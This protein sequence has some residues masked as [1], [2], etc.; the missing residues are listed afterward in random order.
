MAV[1]PPVLK[2]EIDFTGNPTAG[3]AD[4]LQGQDDV[5]SF[6][7]LNNTG[8]MLDSVG[9]NP[10]VIEGTPTTTTSPLLYDSDPAL[11]FN[12]SS[13][14][15]YVPT[16]ANL[17]SKA[18]FTAAGWLY[19]PSLPAG[20]RDVVAKRGAWLL[21][22]NSTGNLIFT[23]KD[24]TST[25][26]VTTNTALA[27]STWYHIA[28]V[29]NSTGVAGTI[30]IYINGVLDNQTSYFAG[31]EAGFQPIRFAAAP[32]T[33]SPTWQSSQTATG[34][35]TSVIVNAPAS[36]APG[37]MLLAHIDV[38]DIVGLTT[39][40]PPTGW[41]LLATVAN[42]AANTTR[43]YYKIATGSEPGSY[44]WAISANRT[45]EGAI[46]RFTG[47]DTVA[48]F[49]NPVYAVATPSGTSHSAGTHVPN[50]DNNTVVAFFALRGNCTWT[51]SSGTERYDAGSADDG[52]AMCTQTQATAASLN[53]TGTSSIAGKGSAIMVILCG[54]GRQYVAASYKDW[55]FENVVRTADDFLSRYE[56]RN[57]GVGT[58]ID[59]TNISN[60]VS[61][62]SVDIRGCGRQY[63]R[64]TIEGGTASVTFNDPNRWLDPTNTLSP[65][66]PN[67]KKNRK[68][69]ITCTF[70]G[71]TYQ[72]F[73][74]FI[75][76]FPPVWNIPRYTEITVT[77]GDGFKPL[78][79][80]GVSGTLPV[81]FSGVQINKLLN[82]ALW[83]QANRAVDTGAYVMAAADLNGFAKA[84]IDTV[85]ESELG[86]FFVDANG[87][88]SFHDKAHRGSQTRST[89][90]QATFTDTGGEIAYQDL[91]PSDDE[92]KII[93][94]WQVTP[95]PSA[96]GSVMQEVFDHPSM[97]GNFPRTQ[98]RTTR[99]ASNTDAHAQA[100]SLL[101][102]TA[103]TS[104]R[105]DA[106]T[107][108]PITTLGFQKCL[109]LG[110][111]D[112][113]TVVR[114]PGSSGS[115]VSKDCF[116][117]GTGSW[118]I[119]PGPAGAWQVSFPLSPVSSGN[120]FATIIRDGP[121]SFYRMAV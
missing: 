32:S 38:S 70:A 98:S 105:F 66:Y 113:V 43:V 89:T 45:W 121:V 120:Y 60:G 115:T 101:N 48:P 97:A 57:S 10:G 84:E 44:T 12:G 15:A 95:D 111:S 73:K 63:E 36:I 104:T 62:K 17:T 112:R 1:A 13:N 53:V 90:S 64:G 80:A 3:H 7:R 102:E 49:S 117:E 46:S 47:C 85:V 41:F 51:E 55:S 5:T 59:V 78:N 91:T 21:Q 42:A 37:D 77:A 16:A 100:N 30:S 28:L 8:T 75:E 22:A 2:V 50:V 26:S 11:A 52:F 88:A 107:V 14:A 34:I 19:L 99:L 67:V 33:S 86:L 79:L 61:V 119:R 93:N 96:P 65:Y 9:M 18:N 71:S 35:S 23:L 72:L 29:Y 109:S 24:D 81:S 74:G 6:W 106:I 118:S 40:T 110:I 76:R 4:I 25:G 69:R 87:I 116:V 108:V 31:W 39:L 83:P 27:V 103:E 56:S 58:W 54:A 94:D 114:T 68:I 82:K 92:D 20:A